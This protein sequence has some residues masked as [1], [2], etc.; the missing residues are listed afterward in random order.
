MISVNTPQLLAPQELTPQHSTATPSLA[1]AC[2]SAESDRERLVH[3][4]RVAL[5]RA[6]YWELRNVEIAID[7][8]RVLITGCVP[9]FYLKQVSQELARHAAPDH[10]ICNRLDVNS[11][12][13]A[14]NDRIV[15]C[16]K[17][18][19]PPVE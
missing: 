9:S 16:Q 4:V 5:C 3:D 18:S 7:A 19:F 15:A 14:S 17:S 8:D 10:K 2:S 13:L 11:T 12:P 1:P 6:G